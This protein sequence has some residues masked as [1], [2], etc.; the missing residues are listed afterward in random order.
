MVRAQNILGDLAGSVLLHE[1]ERLC[2]HQLLLIIS[3]YW[4]LG[5]YAEAILVVD[6]TGLCGVAWVKSG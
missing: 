3:P 1:R 4:R 5:E 2:H 6:W